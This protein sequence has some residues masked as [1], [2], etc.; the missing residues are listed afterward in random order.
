MSQLFGCGKKK[1]INEF[2]TSTAIGIDLSENGYKISVQAVNAMVLGRKPLDISPVIIVTAEG[3]TI[4]E[5]LMKMST[6]FPSKLFI[7]HI[8]LLIF[9]KEAAEEGIEKFIDYFAVERFSQHNYNIIIVENETAENVLKVQTVLNLVPT[10]AIEGKISNSEEIY[11]L[12]KNT[13]LDET[14]NYIKR[15]GIG[16]VLSSIIIEGD[17][18]KGS[19]GDTNKTADPEARIKVS[20]LA[21]F[22]KDKLI[23]FLT[24]QETLGYKHIVGKIKISSVNVITKDGDTIALRISKVKTK[25]DFKLE[26]NKPKIIVNHTVYVAVSQDL[27]NTIVIEEDIIN[28]LQMRASYEITQKIEAC[29]KRAQEDL[30]SDIFSFSEVIHRKDPKYWA[31]MIDNYDNIFSTLDV[32]VNVE[33]KIKRIR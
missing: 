7:F 10:N 33:T 4:L 2:T 20:N 21:V 28:D 6:Q 12:G 27:F 8:S 30:N 29:L 16:L 11:G 15:Q 19:E 24:E 22:K 26:N 1:D 5:A 18:E 25:T 31:E 32:E 23:G 3:K 14:I 17:P 13:Y 9:S